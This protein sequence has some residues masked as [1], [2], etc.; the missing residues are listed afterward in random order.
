MSLNKPR[1]PGIP[2]RPPV[3]IRNF[4]PSRCGGEHATHRL[5]QPY[6]AGSDP[7]E[8]SGTGDWYRSKRVNIPPERSPH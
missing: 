8:F 2:S 1:G 3:D 5:Q 4:M 6:L 7:G